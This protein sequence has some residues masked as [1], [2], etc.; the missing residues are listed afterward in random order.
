[1]FD[2][3]LALLVLKSFIASF[4]A[5]PPFCFFNFFVVV[6]VIVTTASSSCGVFLPASLRGVLVLMSRV[7]LVVTSLVVLVLDSSLS[8][9]QESSDVS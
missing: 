9:L 7:I 1:M 6:V 5:F 4:V 3:P 8:S 2:F